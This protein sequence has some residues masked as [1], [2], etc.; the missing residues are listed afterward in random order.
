MLGLLADRRRLPG[1]YHYLAGD[2]IEKD[3]RKLRSDSTRSWSSGPGTTASRPSSSR[4]FQPQP[5]G[6]LRHRAVPVAIGGGA[7]GVEELRARDRGLPPERSVLSEVR[8]LDDVL[9][10]EQAEKLALLADIRAR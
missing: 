7:A 4:A 10:T 9:P 2:P 1:A 5:V 6:R 3:W 8:S